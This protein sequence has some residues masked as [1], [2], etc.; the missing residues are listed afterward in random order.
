MVWVNK[1]GERFYD[2]SYAPQHRYGGG[3]MMR[4][5]E[6]ARYTLFDQKMVERMEKQGLV[7]GEGKYRV[8]QRA[9]LPG[10]AKGIQSQ[11]EEGNIKMVNSWE[12]MA[13]Y[14]GCDPKARKTTIDK[15]N[16]DCDKG[17][18][19]LIAKDP[20]YLIPLRNPPYY[21]VGGQGGG[22]GITVAGIRIN[23]RMEILDKQHKPIPGL[24]ASGAVAGGWQA[25]DYNGYY[26]SGAAL[27]WAYNSGRIAG[28]NAPEYLKAIG[29]K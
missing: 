9:P 7:T 24:Y 2:E 20:R 27:G 23:E 1:N 8:E 19:S 22:V 13:E 11:V 12:E 18:D 10:L 17:R 14:I 5:P 3:V 26:T 25:I 21:A 4:Q 29:N 15:Y 28:E 16:D 6:Q